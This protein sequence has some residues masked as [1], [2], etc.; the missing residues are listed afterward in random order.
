[1]PYKFIRQF[2][3]DI[4]PYKKDAQNQLKHIM[5]DEYASCMNYEFLQSNESAELAYFSLEMLRLQAGATK[6]ELCQALDMQSVLPSAT[7]GL[8]NTI[9]ASK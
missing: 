9:K 2:Q 3:K 4:A 5:G 8:I 1:M 6:Q 7:K